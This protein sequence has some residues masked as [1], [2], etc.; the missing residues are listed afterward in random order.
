MK[1]TKLPLLPAMIARYRSGLEAELRAA[2]PHMNGGVEADGQPIEFYRM[3]HYHM[4]WADEVGNL[5]SVPTSRGK[6]I[7]PTLCLLSCEALSGEWTKALPA[8]AALEFIHNFSLFTTI[9][10]TGIWR[11]AISP[12]SGPCGGSPRPSLPAMR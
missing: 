12:P 4:G 8:A 2:M 1:N 3:L 6:A 11:G 7:R 9:S 10:R 5:L